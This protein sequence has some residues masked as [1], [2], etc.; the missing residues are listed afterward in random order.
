MNYINDSLDKIP[1]TDTETFKTNALSWFFG[2]TGMIAVVM[3]IVSGIKMTT[4]AG[5][6]G[7]VQKAKMTLLYAIIGLVIAILAYAIINFVL[8]FAMKQ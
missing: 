8:D 5:N 7:A 2:I 3:I 6:P 4:S 1:K